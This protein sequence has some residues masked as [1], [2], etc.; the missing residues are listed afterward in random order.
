MYFLAKPFSTE[1]LASKVREALDGEAETRIVRSS[2][3]KSP[4]SESSQVAAHG[5]TKEKFSPATLQRFTILASITFS[6]IQAA[7]DRIKGAVYH[8]PVRNR[9]R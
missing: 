1:Q 9:S 5:L 8:S 2:S 3:R 7:A 4:T 6:D